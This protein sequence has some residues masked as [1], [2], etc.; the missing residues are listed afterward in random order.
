[1]KPSLNAKSK[2]GFTLMELMITVVVIG[3]LASIAIP[4]YMEY[5]AK[6]RRS[7]AQATIVQ[8]ASWLERFYSENNRYD[9]TTNAGVQTIFPSTLGQVPSQGTPYY[10]VT[11]SA[12]A[13]AT[14]TITATRT[15]TM[16]TDRCGDFTF[17][18]AGVKGIQNQATGANAATCWGQ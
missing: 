2:L 10:T 17:S 4:N 7:E 5:V 14:Y 15:G 3:I 1:M 9:N 6:G 11:V 12:V 18:Q 13:Q 8:L 16:A